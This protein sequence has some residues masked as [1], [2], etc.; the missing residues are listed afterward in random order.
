MN[1]SLIICTYMRPEP[2]LRLLNSV[3]IQ[4]LYP[5]EILIIDGSTNA[6]T[7]E[8]LKFN[9]FKKLNYFRA[10]DTQ[11]GLTKQRNFG[12]QKVSSEAEI[13]CFLDDDTVLENDY[14]E[15]LLS[16]YEIYPNTLGVGGYI[17]N[18][19]VWTKSKTLTSKN[20]FF[21][22]GFER[23]EPQ[24][25]RVRRF[26]GLQPNTKPCILPEFSHGRSV[27]FLPPS[28]KIYKVEQ[29][30]G[31]VSSFKKQ[32][33]DTLSFSTYFEGYGLYEDAD[34]TL[35]LS[36]I[37]ELYVNTSARLSHYHDVSGRPNKFK[38]GKMVARNG[39]Y[40]WRVKHPNPSL[41]NRLKWNLTFILL[42]KLRFVNVF[43]TRNRMEAISEGF[44]R[45]FGWLSLIFN[46]PTIER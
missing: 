32:V 22:D 7:E 10:N 8:I 46:K 16:A 11:R 21:Y 1:F 5:N 29:F 17:T 13:I 40:V 35:R 36:K 24:R 39:W 4:T 25:F 23:N 3:K 15:K 9:S 30:M 38:Y 14:F 44:G 28:D 18:E 6:K 33:F 43:T 41:K 20:K 12:I 31:G 37:G 26:F 27:S 19:V 45:F 34:F 42:M 2:L